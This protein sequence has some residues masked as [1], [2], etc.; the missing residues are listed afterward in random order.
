[1]RPWTEARR[2]V[3]AGVTGGGRSW[4]MPVLAGRNDGSGSGVPDGGAG[5]SAEAG[6]LQSTQGWDESALLDQNLTSVDLLGV[7]LAAPPAGD[8]A[9]A[10]IRLGSDSTASR[11]MHKDE[12][13]GWSAAVP[14]RGGQQRSRFGF[15]L[16]DTDE[17]SSSSAGPSLV[18]DNTVDSL[19]QLDMSDDSKWQAPLLGGSCEHGVT[20]T[21]PDPLQACGPL[22]GFASLTA[23]GAGAGGGDAMAA[24]RALLPNVNVSFAHTSELGGAGGGGGGGSPISGAW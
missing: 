12:S 4:G 7:G 23:A 3:G 11:F 20:E 10:S 16:T 24:F 15:A 9:G 8:M 1:M 17:A 19:A 18:S 6:A 22:G 13:Q 21:S 14:R 2:D 5:C